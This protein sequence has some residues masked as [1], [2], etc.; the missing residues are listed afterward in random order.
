VTRAYGVPLILNDRPYA[1]KA[2]GADGLHL[3]QDDGSLA[4][5][6]SIVGQERIVGRSTHSPEQALEAEK[7]GFDYIGVGPVFA[8]PTKP[9]YEPVGLEFVKFAAQRIHTPFV[10]IGGIDLGNIEQV[11]KAG[12]HTVAVVRALMG[13]ADPETAAKA[14][15]GKMGA[16]S[17]G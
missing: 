10:A 1:V 6:R 3:G 14:F 13:S 16:R 7:E 12:A 8:T 5:A 15:T 9:S 17:I 11:L 2:S 4:W